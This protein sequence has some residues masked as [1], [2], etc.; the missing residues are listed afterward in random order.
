MKSAHNNAE[1]QVVQSRR[2]CGY[3][4]RVTRVVFRSM[5][6]SPLTRAS[7]C[8]V[9]ALVCALHAIAA[10]PSILFDTDMMTDCDDAGAM[11]VLHALADRGECRILATVVSS[12]EPRSALAVEIFNDYYGRPELPVAMVKGE[13]V[14]AGSRFLEGLTTRFPHRLQADAIPDARPLY[15]ETLE[16]EPDGSVT[17]VTVGYLTN[18]RQL[19]ESPASEGHLSGLELARRKVKRLV[20]MGG[21]FIGDP[22]RDDL[23]LGNVNFQRDAR[24]AVYVIQNWPGALDFVG[25]EI[26]SVP[27]GLQLG[28]HLIRTPET[29]PVRVAYDLYGGGVK[30]R[31]VADL[32][33]V[34][35]AVRGLRDYWDVSAPGHMEIQPDASFVWVPEEH[36]RQRY[37]RKRGDNDRAIEAALDELL[38]QPPRPREATP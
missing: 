36:G 34:L 3:S 37:L 9:A 5:L 8:V 28:E 17:V 33:T 4:F 1:H 29:N 21:N 19:L 14:K 25:R 12:A 35:Y 32:T 23:K 11:A 26:G 20:C 16:R 2:F 15:R 38:L 10:P 13:G 31:H 27:S 24:S 18:V 7:C 6:R 30:N 22:P